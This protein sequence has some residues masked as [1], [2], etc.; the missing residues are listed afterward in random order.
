MFNFNVSWFIADL[1]GND[2]AS[3]QG[4]ASASD[5]IG[6]YAAMYPA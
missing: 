1:E 5:Y 6:P 4:Y 3:V 2:V